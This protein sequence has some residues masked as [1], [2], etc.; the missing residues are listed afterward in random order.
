MDFDLDDPLGD[1]LSD[2]SNDS[3]FGSSKSK[4]KSNETKATNSSNP[5]SGP[6][7]S[8]YKM[9]DLFGISSDKLEEKAPD[10]IS[11]YSGNVNAT[12]S[13]SVFP[14]NETRKL[15]ASQKASSKAPEVETPKVET[16]VKADAVTAIVTRPAI[17]KEISFGDSDDI[18]SE[19]GFDPKKPRSAGKKSS[20]LDDLLGITETKSV[21][22]AAAPPVRDIPKTPPRTAQRSTI[23]E[24]DVGSISSADI[25]GRTSSRYSP[26]L[27]R[28]RTTPRTNSGTS[29]NDPLGLFA[30]PQQEEPMKK[31]DVAD[32]R[33][34]KASRLVKKPSMVDWLGLEPNKESADMTN[35]QKPTISNQSTLVQSAPPPLQIQ[36]QMTPVASESI[37]KSSNILNT[38]LSQAIQ[39][40]TAA[41]VDGENALENLQQQELQLQIASQMRNQEVALMDMQIKQQTLLKQQEANFNDLLRRQINRQSALEDSIK[42]QQEQINT[43]IQLLMSQ[44]LNARGLSHIE[45]QDEIDDTNAGND[46]KLN[47]RNVNIELKADVKKLELEKLRLEDL[48]QNIRNNHEQELELIE[49]SHK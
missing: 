46:I 2:G 48:V 39:L 23:P 34:S 40:I 7:A 37:L 8:K 10:T 22:P 17:K 36:N 26:S 21:H 28:P 4:K 47:S 6:S 30:A 20:I 13:P 25:G 38:D 18:L 24:P 44:P 49:S 11:Q 43:H 32:T 9:E 12:S 16:P 45:N 3:F 5:K 27:G 14:K 1:L 41:N 19:L 42:R 15:P 29:L 31:I 35:Q 33:E